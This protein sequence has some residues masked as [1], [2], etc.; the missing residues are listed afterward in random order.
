MILLSILGYF[1]ARFVIGRGL[2]YIAKRSENQVDEIIIKD[3]HPFWV[4]WLAPLI[5]IYL[6]AY[7]LP[8]Y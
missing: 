7:V 4:A 8:E 6:L 5:V 3:I 2:T 1:I